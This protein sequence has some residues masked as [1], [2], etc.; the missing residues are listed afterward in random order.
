MLG[1]VAGVAVLAAVACAAQAQPWSGI[2]STARAV[3]WTTAGV[4]GGIPTDWANCTNTA[5]NTLW[6]GTV[7]S[8]SI[9]NAIS[10]A[11]SQTVVRIPSGTYTGIGRINIARSDVILRGQGAGSTKLVFGTIGAGGCGNSV[12]N[13]A[14]EMTNSS[15][16]SGGWENL[17]T[18]DG[19]SLSGTPSSGTYTQGSTKLLVGSNTGMSVGRYLILDQDDDTSRPASGI[20]VCGFTGSTCS[21]EGASGGGGRCDSSGCGS[22]QGDNAQMQYARITNISGTTITVTPGLMMDNWVSAK[23]PQIWWTN[24]PISYVGIEDVKLD[25]SSTSASVALLTNSCHNCWLKG[26]SILKPTSARANIELQYSSRVTV[27]DSYIVGG[28]GTNL[29]YGIENWMTGSILVENNILHKGVAAVLLGAST[30]SVISYNFIVDQTASSPSYDFWLFPGTMEHNAGILATLYEGNDTWS[31]TQDAIH[32]SHAISTFFRNRS[33]GSDDT[34]TDFG[35]QD[36]QTIPLNIN[37]NSRYSNIIGN[38]FGRAGYHDNYQTVSTGGST[39]NCATSIYTI[40]FGGYEHACSNTAVS[41]DNLTVTG[42]MR[43]GNY[44]VVTGTVRWCGAS[45]NTGWSTT[46]AST[47][48]VP[49]GDSSYPNSVPAAET[50]PASFYLAS[51]PSAWWGTPWGT[52]AWPPIGPDVSGGNISE[53][54]GGEAGLDGHAYKIPARLCFENTSQTGGILDFDRATCYTGSGSPSAPTGFR[55]I[56]LR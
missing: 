23:T 48:E 20:Y 41:A 13:C 33:R 12:Y 46:C 26:I 25:A 27:R 43:W 28:E 34:S 53:G 24:S 15:L 2:V 22:G 17:T 39:A 54:S 42:A 9:N 51:Q 21:G 16:W 19:A 11:P 47:S 30:G 44:D 38:V 50:L 52:P 10:G 14:V 4:D 32:G 31:M 40:G 7:T 56:G 18:F 5:C 49:T 36:S 6:G 35:T 45:G 55:L 37:A 8:T 29:S 1:R 3:D